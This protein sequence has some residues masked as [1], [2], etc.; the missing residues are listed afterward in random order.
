MVANDR[1]TNAL[2]LLAPVIGGAPDSVITRGVGRAVLGDTGVG[3]FITEADGA[4]GGSLR[5]VWNVTAN[6]LAGET[7]LYTIAVESIF[8]GGAVCSSGRS[9]T[10]VTFI[11]IAAGTCGV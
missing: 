10:S 4:M 2:A 5:A 11:A 6:T 1:L 7:R 8:A 9:A 3:F